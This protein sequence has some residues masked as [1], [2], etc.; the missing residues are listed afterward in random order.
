MEELEP[1]EGISR[2]KMMKRIG[3]G[4]AIAWTAPI[5]TSIRTPAFAQTAGPAPCDPG[6]VCAACGAAQACMGN[7]ACNCWLTS[8]N[9]CACLNFVQFCG[10]TPPC[11][12]GQ[13]DC[14]A[15]APGDT[16]IQTCC[17]MICAPPCTG[18]KVARRGGSGR[19]TR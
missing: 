10:Q 18:Q 2:R 15:A 17:G 3:A 16:C 5:L 8:G 6:Q 4:A 14:D 12:N 19:T 9:V 1:K 7:A 13:A 11:P